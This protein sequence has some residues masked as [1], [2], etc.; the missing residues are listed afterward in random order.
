MTTELIRT[1]VVKKSVALARQQLG[2]YTRDLEIARQLSFDFADGNGAIDSSGID[3]SYNAGRALHAVLTLF[4]ETN[5][6]GNAQIDGRPALKIEP[7]VFY[8]AYGVPRDKRGRLTTQGKKESISALLEL[9]EK[10]FKVVWSRTD[11]LALVRN[12][13]LLE[14]A[15]LYQNGD[16]LVLR[17]RAESDV[18]GNLV[19]LIITYND[20]V[21]RH[22]ES[23]YYFVRADLFVDVDR[24]LAEKRGTRRGRKNSAIPNLINYLLSQDN[25]VLKPT[26][27]ELAERL[28]VPHAQ[29]RHRSRMRATVDEALD[30]ALDRGYLD[31]VSPATYNGREGYEIRLNLDT[32]TRAKRR[33]DRAKKQLAGKC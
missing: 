19:G 21:V 4:D 8:D 33:V 14:V 16:A 25:A 15:R 6:E 32:C 28:R 5:Y 1:R 10:T 22:L 30:Y 7:L 27:R 12:I 20:F 23:F 9:D 29:S 26:L 31:R 18:A 3:T 17:T 13:R 2:D 11:G 24:W